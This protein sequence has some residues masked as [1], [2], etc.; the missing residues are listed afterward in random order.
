MFQSRR[1]GS[2][3]DALLECGVMRLGLA[4][5]AAPRAAFRRYQDEILR[6]S[7]RSS[8]TGFRDPARIVT[9]G[10]LDSLACLSL[11]PPAARRVVDIGSG[12]GFPAL[13]MAIVRRDLRFTLVEASRRKSSFLRHICRLLALDDVRVLRARA[14]A[15]AVET[16]HAGAYDLAMA[17]AVAHPGL[18]AELAEPFLRR[19]GVFLAQVGSS[20]PTSELLSRLPPDRLALVAECPLPEFLGGPGRRLI[21][22]RRL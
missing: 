6:W 1:P 16:E 17:R 10:F 2:D 8:L 20:C 18:Q 14:E 7:E 4:L 22:L 12:A 13:P 21:L 19:G 5:G 3:P 15:A 11:V 9:E